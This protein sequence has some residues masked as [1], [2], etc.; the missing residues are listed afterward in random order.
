MTHWYCKTHNS[1]IPLDDAEFRIERHEEFH[2]M[3]L[4]NWGTKDNKWKGNVNTQMG[5]CEWILVRPEEPK[6]FDYEDGY[7]INEVFKQ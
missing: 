7:D 1:D 4:T 3:R 5:K 2:S 6:G